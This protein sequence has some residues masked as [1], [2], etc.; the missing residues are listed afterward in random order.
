MEY[1]GHKGTM[2]YYYSNDALTLSQWNS[3]ADKEEDALKAIKHLENGWHFDDK[4]EELSE[5]QIKLKNVELGAEIVF[6]RESEYI[7]TSI[8]VLPIDC[9]N[10]NSPEYN[11]GFD[12]AENQMKDIRDD[13]LFNLCCRINNVIENNDLKAFCGIKPAEYDKKRCFKKD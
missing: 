12:S 11:K 3:T 7:F 4:D 5:N 1:C 6:N 13:I 8:N 2:T 9:S 10:L